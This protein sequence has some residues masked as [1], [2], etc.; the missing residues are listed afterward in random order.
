MAKG[1]VLCKESGK[2]IITFDNKYSWM[3]G[4]NLYYN[5]TQSNDESTLEWSTNWMCY[6]MRPKKNYRNFFFLDYVICTLYK[7]SE[8]ITLIYNLSFTIFDWFKFT[9]L[10]VNTGKMIIEYVLVSA[11]DVTNV[12][13]L[14]SNRILLQVLFYIEIK[15]YL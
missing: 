6:W 8:L 15:K 11:W 14:L 12:L 7:N 2:Y 1:Q 5:I 9:N 4:K 3:R 13:T 10:Y